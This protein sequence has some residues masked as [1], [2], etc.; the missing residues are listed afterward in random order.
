[1]ILTFFVELKQLYYGKNRKDSMDLWLQTSFAGK[2]L[3]I[4][5]DA[6]KTHPKIYKK[7]LYFKAFELG[8]DLHKEDYIDQEDWIAI[9][10]QIDETHDYDYE[11]S[12]HNRY[13]IYKKIKNY[14]D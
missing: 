8:V 9:E 6:F 13:T 3:Q 14:F 5:N 1:M 10:K 4:I 2:Q 11:I 12:D 7:F